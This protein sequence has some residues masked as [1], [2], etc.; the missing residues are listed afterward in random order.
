VSALLDINIVLPG[1]N[2]D[3]SWTMLRD[4]KPGL[5]LYAPTY[6]I[7]VIHNAV[8]EDSEEQPVFRI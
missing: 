5:I 1:T 4:S 6:A 2:K 3:K 7:A 8:D